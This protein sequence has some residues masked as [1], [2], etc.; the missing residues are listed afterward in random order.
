MHV[1]HDSILTL[2]LPYRERLA[3][4]CPDIVDA[5][6]ANRASVRGL[7]SSNRR[8]TADLQSSPV[9]S[10]MI[11]AGARAPLGAGDLLHRHAT[12]CAREVGKI[13]GNERPGLSPFRP[14]DRPS[15]GGSEIGF[16]M[17]R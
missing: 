13:Q 16:V 14:V 4:R 15:R 8:P 6:G 5:R 10:L 1:H 11:A 12:V 2:D 9:A 7:E 3:L 17:A